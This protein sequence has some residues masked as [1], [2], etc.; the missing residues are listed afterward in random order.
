MIWTERVWT[1]GNDDRERELHEEE[2]LDSEKYK[3]IME[4]VV[5]ELMI[6]VRNALR[7]SHVSV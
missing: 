6:Y 3:V 4:V 5:G 1:N 7:K 2:D